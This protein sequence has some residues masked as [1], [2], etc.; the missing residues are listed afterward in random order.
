MSR[1]GEEE[2]EEEE[3]SVFSSTR[4]PIYYPIDFPRRF[5]RGVRND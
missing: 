1:G 4:D 5:D 3:E 2:E